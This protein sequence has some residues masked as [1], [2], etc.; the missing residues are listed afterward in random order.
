[1]TAEMPARDPVSGLA[2]AGPVDEDY[3]R[4]VRSHFLL[5]PGVAFL[6]TGTAG[7]AWNEVLDTRARID[8]EI[9]TIP[10][11]PYR[12]EAVAAIRRQVAAFIAAD[13]SEV[14]F[15]ASTTQGMNIFAHGIDWKPGDEVVIAR[16]EH[17]GGYQPYETIAKR[18]GI[19]I[20]W[21]DLPSPPDSP[22]RIVDLYERAITPRTRVI[23][24]SHLMYTT[25]LVMPLKELA[26]LAHEKGALISV[27]AAQSLGILPTDVCALA[28]D[29]YAAPGQK[30]LLAGT[31]TGFTYIRQA[32]QGLVWPLMGYDEIG[33]PS[34]FP[35]A[36]YEKV[37]Q[38]NTPAW[39]GIGAAI[40]LHLAVGRENI[41]RRGRQL[42]D[43]L[44]A[45][46]LE[47]P[48]VT[49][50]TSTDPKLSATLTTFSVAGVAPDKLVRTLVAKDKIFIRS[51]HMHDIEAV[52]AST[53][54]YNSPDEVDRL[55]A[56]VRRQAAA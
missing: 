17:F 46:L 25:G 41:E 20:V 32:L 53:H 49:L 47:I 54:F 33:A 37:G 30:W 27:D 44:R 14:F 45:G 28:I 39:L 9:A 42:S 29:H 35:I 55:L 48:G 51:I 23:V 40:E 7:P 50:Y 12:V 10:A 4:R 8:R 24:V 43:R 2:P 5:D 13:P 38:W 56:A 15:T 22:E 21:L 6:N 19:K 36:R 52:R 31:G 18:H 34:A 16:H 11:D 1:M 3:W 26:E